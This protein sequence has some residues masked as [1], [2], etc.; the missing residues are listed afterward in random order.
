MISMPFDIELCQHTGTNSEW[1]RGEDNSSTN[2]N[3]SV[4]L[5]FEIDVERTKAREREKETKMSSCNFPYSFQLKCVCIDGMHIHGCLWCAWC[6]GYLRQTTRISFFRT[7]NDEVSNN[8]RSRTR[9]SI[10]KC[11][12]FILRL[13]SFHW[14]YATR[15]SFSVFAILLLTWGETQENQK[16]VFCKLIAT[17]LWSKVAAHVKNIYEILRQSASTHTRSYAH[18]QRFVS[19]TNSFHCVNSNRIE[20]FPCIKLLHFVQHEKLCD[21]AIRRNKLLWWRSKKII[22]SKTYGGACDT[23]PQ[24]AAIPLPPTSSLPMSAFC[25]VK[26]RCHWDFFARNYKYTYAIFDSLTSALRRLF[27]HNY[28]SDYGLLTWF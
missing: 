9:I 18:S 26:F 24:L 3:L 21:S 10:Y 28:S 17:L 7:N 6:I 2:I 5:K 20:I 12:L 1:A 13:S 22:I 15:I 8:P 4:K 16:H 14:N 23:P 11:Q 25:A 27:L 19:P